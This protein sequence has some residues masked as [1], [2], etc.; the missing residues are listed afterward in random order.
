MEHIFPVYYTLS[1]HKYSGNGT[2]N[3]LSKHQQKY[4]WRE[5]EDEKFIYMKNETENEVSV[6]KHEYSGSGTENK[7]SIHGTHI[8][9]RRNREQVFQGEKRRV[10]GVVNRTNGS[11]TKNYACF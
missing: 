11:N 1:I 4:S 10:G 6:S 5:N 2:E 9:W 7:L 8:F 3:E